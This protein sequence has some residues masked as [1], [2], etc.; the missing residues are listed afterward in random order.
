[1]IVNVILGK[2]GLPK[3]LNLEDGLLYV[4]DSVLE[5]NKGRK[6]ICKVKNRHI[7][8]LNTGERWWIL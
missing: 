6:Y 1:M 8:L 7:E 4:I 3:A 5:I 2:F